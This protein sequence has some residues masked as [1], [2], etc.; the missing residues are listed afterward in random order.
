MLAYHINA[1]HKGIRYNSSEEGCK[2]SR[3]TKGS[4]NSHVH[5]IHLGIKH[6]CK[7]C[8]YEAGQTCQIRKHMIIKHN[9]E[10]FSCNTCSYRCQDSKRMQKHV[11]LRHHKL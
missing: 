9:A 6:K 1:D 7:I 4:L 11:V 3:T 2:F 5:N 10:T 8:E